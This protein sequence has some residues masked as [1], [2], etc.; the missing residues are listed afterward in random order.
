MSVLV[1]PCSYSAFVSPFQGAVTCC[2]Q[3]LA[4]PGSDPSI[5][6]TRLHLYTHTFLYGEEKRNWVTVTDENKSFENE[7]SETWSGNYL[8]WRF[9]AFK[10]VNIASVAAGFMVKMLYANEVARPFSSQLLLVS[11]HAHLVPKWPLR[12]SK[13]P[14]QASTICSLF[15]TASAGLSMRVSCGHSSQPLHKIELFNTLFLPTLSLFRKAWIFRFMSHL[16]PGLVGNMWFSL[17]GAIETK[18]SVISLNILLLKMM[19]THILAVLYA[20]I[21]LLVC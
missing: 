7:V 9:I 1:L 16:W 10:V 21:Y 6:K 4:Q 18:R 13:S 15:S 3:C 17:N 19:W 8:Q 20:W 5:N 12:C 2:W 11:W 14:A